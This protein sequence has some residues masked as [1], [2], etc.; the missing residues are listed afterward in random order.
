MQ[1]LHDDLE[2]Y[3]YKKN[4]G[5]QAITNGNNYEETNVRNKIEK[6]TQLRELRMTG[7]LSE[8]SDEL[9]RCNLYDIPQH[10]FL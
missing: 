10:F 2:K 5:K 8:S 6:I 7:D 4:G 1:L 3:L 9:H